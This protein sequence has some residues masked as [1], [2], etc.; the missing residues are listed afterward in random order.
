MHGTSLA[1]C[2]NLTSSLQN[3]SSFNASTLTAY[4]T[5]E[6]PEMPRTGLDLLWD[7]D[8]IRFLKSCVFN[9][10]TVSRTAQF[11]NEVAVHWK[12]LVKVK[13]RGEESESKVEGDLEFQFP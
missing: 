13:M 3:T 4:E 9:C 5:L 7:G 6:P 11:L 8:A 1:D 12:R 10:N 2:A